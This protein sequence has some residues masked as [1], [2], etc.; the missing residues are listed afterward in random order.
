VKPHA[1]AAPTHRERMIR[2]I[3]FT[4]DAK[5]G[6]PPPLTRT[7]VLVDHWIL[8]FAKPSRE[9]EHVIASWHGERLIEY[10]SFDAGRLTPLW[11]GTP[12][13]RLTRRASMLLSGEWQRQGYVREMNRRRSISTINQRRPSRAEFTIERLEERSLMTANPADI[14]I[15]SPPTESWTIISSVSL[16]NIVPPTGPTGA[17][18]PG[19]VFDPSS[20]GINFNGTLPAAAPDISEWTRTAD[21]DE[22][23]SITGDDFTSFQGGRTKFFV[24]ADS[25]VGPGQIFEA[26]TRSIQEDNRAVIT[27]PATGLPSNAM[28]MIWAVNDAGV[29]RPVFVNQ[30]E[31]W[32]IGPNAGQ[33]GQRI[34]IFGR[35]LSRTG[36]EWTAGQSPGAAP[37]SVWIAP[38]SG[39]S[40]IQVQVT[41]V[42][43]YQVEFEIPANLAS[44]NYRAWVHNGKGGNFGWSAPLDFTVRSAANNATAWNGPIYDSSNTAEL[45]QILTNGT[46]DDAALIQAVLTRAG[47]TPNATVVLPTGTFLLGSTITL[48]SRTRLIGAGMDQTVLRPR[49]VAT[50]NGQTLIL[51]DAGGR[52]STSTLFENFTLHS[53]YNPLGPTDPLYTGG[54][55]Y[56]AQLF[57]QTDITFRNVRFDAR[58]DNAVYVI[59]GN[60]LTFES[61]EFIGSTPM[62]TNGSKQFF[63]ND[64]D[65]YLTNNGSAAIYQWGGEQTSITNSRAQSLDNSDPTR[66]A[67]WGLRFFVNAHGGR[68]KYVGNNHTERLGYAPAFGDN[69]GENILWEGATAAFSGKATSG[70][71][72][73]VTIQNGPTSL[74]FASGR[75]YVTIVQGQGIGQ[76]RRVTAAT[77]NGTT[78]TL[79][80][81]S[82]LAVNL[83]T[84]SNIQIMWM[85]EKSVVYGNDLNGIRENAE[86]EAYIGP[87]GV[88][89]YNGTSDMVIENNEFTNIRR[90]ITIYS[91]T[92]NSTPVS[93]VEPEFHLLVAN[94]RIYGSRT[95][96]DLYSYGGVTSTADVAGR[97]RSGTLGTVFRG[98][99]IDNAIVSSFD[100]SY[101]RRNGNLP[102][103]DLVDNLIIEHNTMTNS[104]TGINLSLGTTTDFRGVAVNEAIVREALIYKNTVT[105]NTANLSAVDNGSKGIIVGMGQTAF[106]IGNNVTGFQQDVGND[107]PVVVRKTG[108]PNEFTFTLNGR[109]LDRKGSRFL[110]S[111]DWNGDGLYE[112]LSNGTR[113]MPGGDTYTFT[114]T[115]A[116]PNVNPSFRIQTLGDNFIFEYKLQRWGDTF[117]PMDDAPISVAILAGPTANAREYA[118]TMFVDNFQHPGEAVSMAFDWNGDGDF[119]DPGE[120]KVGTSSAQW[121]YAFPTAG[122]NNV[123][124][125]VWDQAGNTTA[126]L[127]TV[128]SAAR[129]LLFEGSGKEDWIRLREGTFAAITIDITRVNGRAI[130]YSQ[131]FNSITGSIIAN[132][133]AGPDWLNGSS[134]STRPMNI[135]GGSDSDTIIGGGGNDVIYGGAVPSKMPMMD[136][137][138]FIN[139]G[140]GQNTIY[141]PGGT[142]AAAA[143]E[144]PTPSTSSSTPSTNRLDGFSFGSL[145]DSSTQSSNDAWR[146]AVDLSFASLKSRPITSIPALQASSQATSVA[147]SQSSDEEDEQEIESLDSTSDEDLFD[148]IW[149]TTS[150]G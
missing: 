127:L 67:N 62:F 85:S 140:G 2:R 103:G 133:N 26:T 110:Y 9:P 79:T 46:N 126:G 99:L 4:P 77:V 94:N 92:V 86:R 78:V 75:Y 145:F 112:I 138:N 27:L 135:S 146:N 28:Y 141:A 16:P 37:A 24:F 132:M 13:L 97:Q 107:V 100:V 137:P 89:L 11:P 44:G 83:D 25:G 105:R 124:Y 61:C 56:V 68:F 43:P 73:T 80:L 82:P 148:A 122:G 49:D 18:A 87:A 53:G 81:E 15:N 142:Q 91:Y 6:V 65:F 42:N 74:D 147:A 41:A 102:T 34:T 64:C 32:W 22:S 59:N 55:H 84:T 115:F 117:I 12:S 23:I 50:F 38:Q 120:T 139:G 3:A 131:T 134:V 71:G 150:Q 72:S 29:S 10:K 39:G 30:T 136:A 8:R 54:I 109:E 63:I 5:E 114:Y 111:A 7:V 113:H 1:D 104:P 108:N 76:N 17:T 36:N 66:Q 130:N 119:T 40:A 35:N 58:V 19:E 93:S 129:N 125:K 21:G 88:M 123:Y 101:Q 69:M 60:R 96:I 118:F 143:A 47:Q 52:N 20:A 144:A 121:T 14:L 48:P 106:L 98:N 149:S 90:A 95:G 57:D 128:N 51:S 45:A 70:S 33:A 31:A 116:N